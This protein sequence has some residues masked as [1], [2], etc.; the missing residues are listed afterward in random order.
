M[1]VPPE[2]DP[3]EPAYVRG[4]RERR[5]RVEFD[6][7]AWPVVPPFA[8]DFEARC[9]TGRERMAGSKAV[10]CGLARDVERELLLNLARLERLGQ[11]FAD[12]R[13]LVYEND[14]V[15]A[16]RK[17]LA[18]AARRDARVGVIGEPDGSPR[19]G[20]VRDRERT[21]QLARYR[22]CVRREV[23]ARCEGFDYVVVADFDLEGW[24]Y[25][26]VAHAFGHDDWDVM[27][28]MG[29]RFFA[30][31]P[32]FYDGFAFRA[33]GQLEPHGRF[34]LRSMVFPRG[35]PPIRVDSAFSGLAI[36]P[37]AAFAAGRYDGR[38]CEH[39]RFHASLRAAGYDRVFLNPNML[40]L[41]PE[42]GE[43]LC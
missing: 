34:T 6:E 17:I 25:E 13:I 31:R 35:T 27:A 12:H 21:E 4:I 33:C 23:V 9:R 36:Y 24:S 38:D 18:E 37:M 32:Y 42:F 43:D 11:D 41:Y 28:S 2:P 26:G 3:T 39:V 22:E 16:T 14:S 29:V 5:G 1:A 15:D 10:F 30:G 20:P 40:S 7:A 8:A 19:W